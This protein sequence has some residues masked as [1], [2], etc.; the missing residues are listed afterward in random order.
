[1]TGPEEGVGSEFAGILV[2][3][4]AAALEPGRKRGRGGGIQHGRLFSSK[5]IECKA[6][7]AS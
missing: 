7:K 5:K 3:G 1:M 6:S 2:G 4:L